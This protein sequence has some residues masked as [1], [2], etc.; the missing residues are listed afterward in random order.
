[1]FRLYYFWLV[2]SK[3]KKLI[4]LGEKGYLFRLGLLGVYN[5]QRKKLDFLKMCIK[6]LKLYFL[7]YI[8]TCIAIFYVSTIQISLIA[9]Q[10][11]ELNFFFLG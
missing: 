10:F 1:M 9:K 3:E 5:K 11:G 8:C 2:N 6:Y 4:F 7:V